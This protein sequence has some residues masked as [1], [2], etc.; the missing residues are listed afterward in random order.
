MVGKRIEAFEKSLVLSERQH[1][2]SLGIDRSFNPRKVKLPYLKLNS[3]IH[4]LSEEDILAKNA[5]KI[6]FRPVQDS[7]VWMIKPYATILMILLRDLLNG[8]KEKFKSV[9][10]IDSMHGENVSLKMRKLNFPEENFKFFVSADMSSAYS[11]IFKKDVFGAIVIGT[12]ILNVVD[13][14]RDIVL[15]LSEL[16]LSANFVECS[17]GIYQLVECLPMG[18]SASQD[19]LNIVGTIHELEL[20]EGVAAR[21]E[22]NVIVDESFIVKIIIQNEV[23]PMMKLSETENKALKLFMRYIDDTQGV[24]SSESLENAKAVIL[25]I[26]RIYPAHL[27]VNATMN[28]ICFSHLDCIGFVGFYQNKVKTVVRRNFSAPVNLVPKM[29]NCPPTNKYCIILSELIRYRRICSDIKFVKL[30]ED[31]LFSELVKTGYSKCVL[32]RQ[33]DKA[34]ENIRNNYIEDTFEKKVNFEKNDDQYFCGKITFDQVSGRHK[35]LKTLLSGGRNFRVRNV[36]VPSFKIKTY[37]IS[38]RKHLK[39]LRDFINHK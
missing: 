33:F 26:L 4:K 23:V 34:R 17:V 37:L 7:S 29:S 8:L 30:N 15:K 25:K 19:C 31:F 12:G 28:M 3:K 16:V 22:V 36:L 13:W 5:S 39:R 10:Q 27:V 2:D 32:R 38:K 18:S 20:L 1:L 11:N 9:S 14:R 6:K 35:I 24:Y 21:K